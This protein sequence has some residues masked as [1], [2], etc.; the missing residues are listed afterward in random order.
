MVPEEL[1]ALSAR[2]AES[3]VEGEAFRWEGGM[4]P[5]IPKYIDQFLMVLL[6]TLTKGLISA[7]F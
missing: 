3:R 5:H 1:S 7:A 6:E 2:G 4:A